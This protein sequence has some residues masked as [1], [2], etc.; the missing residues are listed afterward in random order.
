VALVHY[1]WICTQLQRQGLP[2]TTYNIAM[3]WNAGIGAV[4][5]GQVPQASRQ[6]AQRVVNIARDLQ[7]SQVA[8]NIVERAPMERIVLETYP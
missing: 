4:S 2:V 5:S 6:Y 3:T 7:R 1:D 8:V